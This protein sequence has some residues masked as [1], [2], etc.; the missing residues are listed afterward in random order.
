MID[1]E[2]FN[3]P[4]SHGGHAVSG[5]KSQS[6]YHAHLLQ[7]NRYHPYSRTS[8]PANHPSHMVPSYHHPLRT[9][10]PGKLYNRFDR[11][12]PVVDAWMLLQA[13][14]EGNSYAKALRQEATR[15]AE[16]RVPA[17]VAAPKPKPAEPLQLETHPNPLAFVEGRVDRLNRTP[18]EQATVPAMQCQMCEGTTFTLTDDKDAYVCQCG[19]VL[20]ARNT[21]SQ[22]REKA[23][24]ESEDKTIRADAVYEP[25]LT[26]FDRPAPSA[27]ETR[28]ERTRENTNT[29]ISNSQAKKMGIGYAHQQLNRQAAVEARASGRV[30]ESNPNGWSQSERSKADMLMRELEKL[31]RKNQPLSQ[32]IQ[33]YLRA[34]TSMLWERVVRH[35]R[36]CCGSVVCKKKLSGRT[37]KS[38]AEA[39]FDYHVDQLLLGGAGENHRIPHEEVRSLKER[40]SCSRRP[41]NAHMVSTRAMVSLIIEQEVEAPC[42]NSEMSTPHTPEESLSGSRAQSPSLVHTPE[43]LAAAEAAASSE[44]EGAKLPRN[45]SLCPSNPEAVPSVGGGTSD[46]PLP[47]LLVFRQSILRVHKLFQSMLPLTVKEKATELLAD[48]MFTTSLYESQATP[49]ERE[50]KTAYALLMALEATRPKHGKERVAQTSHVCKMVGLR[51]DEAQTLTA[52]VQSLVPSTTWTKA[53]TSSEEFDGLF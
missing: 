12:T 5:G 9:G 53:S 26:R 13:R 45:D 34:N 11:V 21:L 43:R 44:A 28:R 18:E 8:L 4:A 51:D 1:D 40:W 41:L 38:I 16:L 50:A 7:V 31:I 39:A 2:D 47:P 20:P 3:P 6:L 25:R 32:S 22:H 48:K 14:R 30:T 15:R 23:C 37:V 29:Y 19:T 27:E 10:E 42:A 52:T 36:V 17:L 35:E 33:Y 46:A 49:S 24:D